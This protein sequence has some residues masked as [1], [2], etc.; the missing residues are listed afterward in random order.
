MLDRPYSHYHIT[1]DESRIFYQVNFTKTEQKKFDLP[2]LVFNYGL[3][4]SNI[5]WEKQLE[6]FLKENY[7]ILIYNYRGHYNSTGNNDLSKCNFVQY[8][9]DL[10][11]LLEE[12][13]WNNSLVLIG[14]S[15]GVN[16]TLEFAKLYPHLKFLKGLIL[17]SGTILSPKNIIFDSNL[18]DLTIPHLEKFLKK[19]PQPFH[20]LWK[21]SS[22]IPFVQSIVHTLG[23]NRETVPKEFIQKYLDRIAMLGPELFFQL[24]NEMSNHDMVIH[25]ESIKTK[26]LV[27]CGD[28]DYIIPHRYQRLLHEKLPHSEFYLIKNGSHVPQVDYPQSVN[29]R[30]HLFLKELSS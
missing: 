17:I 15:M 5:H 6:Y 28:K 18:F 7:P 1:D 8:A 12:I 24:F 9:K 23:F 14:H 19:Y 13:N 22:K 4:C 30:M 20:K 26:S 21:V 29:E 25:L 27:M 3:V 16:V 11:S 10:H 2:L